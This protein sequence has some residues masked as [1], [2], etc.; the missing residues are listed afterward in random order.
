MFGWFK[1]ESKKFFSK[2]DSA[3]LW[4]GVV[5]F[6]SMASEGVMFDWSG[7]YFQKVVKVSEEWRTTGYICF[8]ACMT[9]GRMSYQRAR[10]I[11]EYRAGSANQ[12][13]V[14]NRPRT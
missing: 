14:T 1:K 9:T 3:L 10:K 2:P 11:L 4:L 8:M 6:C 7:V 13:L 5:G 12:Q